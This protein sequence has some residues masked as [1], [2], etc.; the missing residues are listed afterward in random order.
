MMKNYLNNIFYENTIHDPNRRVFYY[1]KHYKN[2]TML[3][4]FNSFR[5][6]I[7]FNIFDEFYSGRE[8]VFNIVKN[9]ID[10]NDYYSLFGATFYFPLRDLTE[11][12][13]FYILL[14]YGDIGKEIIR[15]QLT[16]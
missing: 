16:E 7:I 3:Y 9:F 10:I 11:E 4:F 8:N 6:D 12:E 15:E 13:K 14:K 2:Y 5:E 1:Q